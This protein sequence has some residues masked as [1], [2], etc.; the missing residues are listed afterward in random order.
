MKKIIDYVKLIRPQHYIKNILII[1]PVFFAGGIFDMVNIKHILGGL[2]SFSLIASVVYIINDIQ[3]MELDKQHEIKRHRPLPSG[4]VKRVEAIGLAVVLL[5]GSEVIQYFNLRG[6]LDSAN[7]ILITYLLLNV[8]YSSGLKNRP[9]IDVILLASGFVLRVLY[10]AA[11]CKVE[12]SSWFCLTVMMFS[13]Y[14]GLGKRRNEL[15]KNQNIEGV[16]RK[17][18]QFY[19]DEFLSRNMLMCMTLGL[20][21]Y[22]YWSA[23][24]SIKSEWMVWTV[25]IVIAILMKYEL[26][27]DKDGFGDPVDVLLSDRNLILLVLLYGI[28]IFLLLYFA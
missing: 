27:I 9:I 6:L 28:V 14:M 12:V 20:V 23:I 24:V 13:L 5:I 1:L 4:E 25:P 15:R 2:I 17:V 16:T 11:I 21:F 8:A 22:S 10:G 3:D 26:N 18:L 19:S 7:I